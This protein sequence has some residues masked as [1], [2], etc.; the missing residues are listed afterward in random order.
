VAKV[1]VDFP[2]KNGNRISGLIKAMKTYDWYKKNPA[3]VDVL[4]LDW[5]KV[6]ADQTFVLERNLYQCACG[7]ENRAVAFPDKLRQ[8]LAS[9][10]IDRA[11]DLLSGM[12][13][14][15]YFDAAVAGL[16]VDQPNS[17][18]ITA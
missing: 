10:P 18:L 1:D 12:F 15:V 2:L 8:E 17:V 5:G 11:L 3:I 6:S 14:E 9:I 16:S 4:K 13:F 7:N